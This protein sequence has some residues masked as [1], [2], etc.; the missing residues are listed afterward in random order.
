MLVD[1]QHP[2]FRRAWVR[3]LCGI[4]PL[5][6]AGVEYAS[7]NALWALLFA[8]AGAY[9]AGALFILRKPEP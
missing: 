8:A 5:A 1:P 4:S 2:F 9:L 7:G 3:V 6:G